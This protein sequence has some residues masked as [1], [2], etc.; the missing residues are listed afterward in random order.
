MQY[1]FGPFS[2]EIQ[3]FGL[4]GNGK[5]LLVNDIWFTTFGGVP[6]VSVEK[7]KI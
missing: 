4:P 2:Y 3:P 1:E 7:A 6:Y 5:I